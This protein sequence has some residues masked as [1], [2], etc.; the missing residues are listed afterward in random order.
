MMSQYISISLTLIFLTLRVAGQNYYPSD[1][2]FKTP[3]S[4]YSQDIPWQLLEMQIIYRLCPAPLIA[5]SGDQTSTLIQA[6]RMS[7]V[8]KDL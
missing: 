5:G 3:K 7:L 8:R 6:L 2:G 1:K 4:I